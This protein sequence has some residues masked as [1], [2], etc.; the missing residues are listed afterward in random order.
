MLQPGSSLDCSSDTSALHSVRCLCESSILIS[1]SS[2]ILG[3]LDKNCFTGWQ[4]QPHT[5]D[6]LVDQASIFISPRDRVYQLHPHMLSIHFSCLLTTHVDYVQ[7]ILFPGHHTGVNYEVPQS[8]SWSMY[9]KGLY[10][11]NPRTQQCT[12]TPIPKLQTPV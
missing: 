2:H 12:P 9:S 4:S 3:L 10:I 8:I 11:W 5:Y 7:A 6:S 1:Y